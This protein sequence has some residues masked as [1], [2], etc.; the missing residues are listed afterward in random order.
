MVYHM[1]DTKDY[2]GPNG[3]APEGTWKRVWT[4][5]RAAVDAF[6]IDPHSTKD[7]IRATNK[8]GTMGDLYDRSAEWSEKR[9]DKEGVDPIKQKWYDNYS[10]KRKGRKHPQQQREESVKNLKGKGID[11]EWGDWDSAL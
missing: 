1:N 6:K 3:K 11:V 4:K 5:P 10:R 9:A 7:F 2:R 8:R